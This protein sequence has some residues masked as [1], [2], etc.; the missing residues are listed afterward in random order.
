M[1]DQ[2][3]R[4]TASGAWRGIMFALLVVGGAAAS[5]PAAAQFVRVEPTD[6]KICGRADKALVDALKKGDEN[7]VTL[8]VA[9][10]GMVECPAPRDSCARLEST[11]NA[12]VDGTDENFKV[13]GALGTFQGL[14]CDPFKLLE[15]IERRTR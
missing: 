12:M 1:R 11:L 8:G 15:M 5:T 6:P 4:R 13:I 10:F 14:R 9:F 3:R 7:A 2:L